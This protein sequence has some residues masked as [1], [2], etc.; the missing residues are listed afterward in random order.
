MGA[1][2]NASA[3]DPEALLALN[4]VSCNTLHLSAFNAGL[5]E[6]LR[7][8]DILPLTATVPLPCL[9]RTRIRNV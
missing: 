9:F 5:S 1:T 6:H 4:T 3:V 8:S 2:P 7:K